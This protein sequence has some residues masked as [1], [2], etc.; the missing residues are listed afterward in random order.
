MKRNQKQL[1][2]AML[3]MFSMLSNSAAVVAQSKDKKQESKFAT[4][5]ATAVPNA[6][7]QNGEQTQEPSIHIASPAPGQ[8]G[9]QV[10]FVHNG[11]S[12]DGK[13]VKD[14]PYSGD[15]VT[16][17][18]QILNSGN[19]LVQNSS[20]KIYRDS[21]GRT[22][23]EQAMK[24][25]GPWAVSGV[26]PIMISIYDPV[27]GVYYNLDSNTKTA[28]KMT[29]PRM[30]D[31]SEDVRAGAKLKAKRASGDVAGAVVSGDS[32]SAGGN[33]V[34]WS[35]NAEI[36]KESLGTQTIEGV[37]AEGT[38]V[39]ITSP[40]GKIGNDH[41][42]VTVNERWYSP[43]LQVVVMSKDSDPRMGE[44]TYRLTNIVRSEPDPSLFQV[45]ADYKVEENS[46]N[47]GTGPRVERFERAR[48]PN[49]N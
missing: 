42:I 39:T 48:K 29:A 6:A 47:F 36:N 43:E 9:P 28:H 20:A 22:R 35:S 10:E 27:S 40:A 5:Q 33:A 16:E 44:T 8:E 30:P 32:I 46:I 7:F 11:I 15:A 2:M 25:G 24:E 14:K 12:F 18:V 41:P 23:R 4:R 19:R 38:R 17:M 37:E 13:V 49:D 31:L 1:L 3:C 45:P 26:A 34:A 21:A